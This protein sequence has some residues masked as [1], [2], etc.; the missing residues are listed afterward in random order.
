MWAAYAG[1]HANLSD[2]PALLN[3]LRFI[4]GDFDKLEE[5]MGLSE[6]VA[7]ELDLL[8]E[9]MLMNKPLHRDEF[10]FGELALTLWSDA[11]SVAHGSVLQ[12][13]DGFWRYGKAFHPDLIGEH[14]FIK[15]LL[16]AYYTL[17]LASHH[18]HSF[19]SRPHH[20]VINIDNTA[21]AYALHRH[22]STSEAGQLIVDGFYSIAAQSN[23]KI[24]IRIVPTAC[25][26]ADGPS[27]LKDEPIPAEC[28]HHH[29]L[30]G[31]LP[32]RRHSFDAAW[33]SD[34]NQSLV[35]SLNIAGVCSRSSLLE[36]NS[37]S[38]SST[39]YEEN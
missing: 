10:E 20:V 6:A 24:R 1:L 27:R 35:K 31:F 22:Y 32:W 8:R 39:L 4:S 37:F 9:R 30:L 29:Q 34:N 11:S 16:A 28:D 15:E 7:A 13:K 23:T 38:R 18:L 19:M 21:A 33:G 25:M 2:Y 14:I 26:L 3:E 5:A 36:P 12:Y 17:A